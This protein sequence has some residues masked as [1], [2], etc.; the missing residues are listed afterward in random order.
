VEELRSLSEQHA[1]FRVT[2]MLSN[3]E[4]P[5][6]FRT[7]LVH[8]ALAE[9]LASLAGY[10]VHLAGPPA[11][12]EAARAAALALGAEPLAILAD[13][14]VPTSPARPARRRWLS[15]L[16]RASGRGR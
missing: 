11:M 15:S 12:V 7:G 6:G 14:F 9:T 5:T 16:L 1:N 4:R 8:E 3:P 13:A 2:F 10:N